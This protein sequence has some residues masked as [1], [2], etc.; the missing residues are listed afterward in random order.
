[1]KESVRKLF[2]RLRGRRWA[3]PNSRLPSEPP[4]TDSLPPF[5]ANHAKSGLTVFD[6]RALRFRNL[7]VASGVEET[8]EDPGAIQSAFKI[9]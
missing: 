7:T 5:S 3:G 2:E 6:D 9:R 4:H 8:I 1:M